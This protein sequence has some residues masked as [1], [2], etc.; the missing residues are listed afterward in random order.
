MMSTRPTAQRG[1]ATAL[2]SRAGGTM[3]PARANSPLGR[4]DNVDISTHSAEGSG[5]RLGSMASVTLLSR[6]LPHSSFLGSLPGQLD[7]LRPRLCLSSVLGEG[8]SAPLRPIP[9]GFRKSK[10][11]LIEFF[12]IQ[13]LKGQLLRNCYKGPCYKGPMTPTVYS[14]PILSTSSSRG[15][16]GGWGGS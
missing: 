1:Q 14:V 5:G 3:S 11:R 2:S 9:S 7:E 6:P 8:N 16:R 10:K 4:V 15:G 12:K 13:E